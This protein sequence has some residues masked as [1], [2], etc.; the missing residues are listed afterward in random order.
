[1]TTSGRNSEWQRSRAI[2]TNLLTNV[3]QQQIGGYCTERVDRCI[4][5][6]NVMCNNHQSAITSFKI[7]FTQLFLQIFL[8]AINI[9]NVNISVNFVNFWVKNSCRKDISMS[10]E[11]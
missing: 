5:P 7:I 8:Y 4:I 3:Y 6:I 9:T 1:M 10:L 11:W 2:T